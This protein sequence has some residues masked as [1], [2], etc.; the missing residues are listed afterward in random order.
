MSYEHQAGETHEQG[1]HNHEFHDLH[2]EHT[3]EGHACSATCEHHQAVQHID[4]MEPV[5]RHDHFRESH[6]H[7]HGPDCGHMEYQHVHTEIDKPHVHDEH[8]GHLDHHKAA[9][10]VDHGRNHTHNEH[11]DDHQKIEHVHGPNCGH[12]EYEEAHNHVDRHAD[13]PSTA[14]SAVDHTPGDTVSSN[15]MPVEAA[16]SQGE[17][18]VI[19]RQKTETTDAAKSETIPAPEVSSKSNTSVE[20]HALAST[21]PEAS[22]AVSINKEAIA[23]PHEQP[24][25]SAKEADAED[26]ATKSGDAEEE[27]KQVLPIERE[28]PIEI[29][30]AA[31]MTPTDDFALE[32]MNAESDGTL[33]A[34][35]PLTFADE[36]PHLELASE[37]SFEDESFGMSD[38]MLTDTAPAETSDT[39]DSIYETDA[40]QQD[41]PENVPLNTG[42]DFKIPEETPSLQLIEDLTTE[43]LP[44]ILSDEGS[45]QELG[46]VANHAPIEQQLNLAD[47]GNGQISEILNVEWPT[48]AEATGDELETRLDATR[49]YIARFMEQA[50]EINSAD[51]DV[52]S[53][54]LIAKLQNMPK[55]SI[56]KLLP[57]LEELTE[58]HELPRLETLLELYF[59]GHY[60]HQNL[61]TRLFVSAAQDTQDIT[62][63]I[64][65]IVLELLKIP[66]QNEISQQV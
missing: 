36:E 15:D 19:S 18:V 58:L 52:M 56:E 30:E 2:A 21:A 43:G 5:E 4:F 49:T 40:L 57:L 50:G 37:P 28:Q 41:F 27:T 65:Q 13:E 23:P 35:M 7:I 34:E 10:H 25:V 45:A 66:K 11:A 62:V 61:F 22:D 31:T 55:E 48:P 46:I 12:V 42:F 9:E 3:H 51:L 63:R 39:P 1:Q 47:F 8:C 20:V 17:V 60:Q 24:A 32:S 38:E 26:R 33:Q 54:Q 16:V 44:S 6:E 53:N 14:E 59:T 64:G 29:L